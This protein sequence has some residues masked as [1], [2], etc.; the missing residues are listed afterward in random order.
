[1]LWDESADDLKLVGAAGL[2]VSGTTSLDG[3]VT[4]NDSGADVDFRVESDGNANMLFVDGGN[5]A[6]GIGTASPMTMLHIFEGEGLYPDDANNH[7]VVESDS[8]SYIGIGGGTSSD[9]G[10]HFGDSG[11]MARGRI[12]YLNASDAMSFN[13]AG[14]EAMRID[15]SGNVGIG[16]TDPSEA[17]L[18]IDNVT[19]GDAGL[20]IVQAQD[21]QG[22]YLD[23]DGNERGIYVEYAGTTNDALQII[24]EGLTTG[25]I[26]Y[27][28]SNTANT[29][30]RDL[31]RIRNNHA[32]ATGTTSLLV[33]Q[34]STGL[35][36][37]FLG[38]KIRTSGGIL[39]GTDTAAANALDD[40]EEGTWTPTYAVGGGGSVTG[41]TSTNVGT[42]T[43]VGRMVTCGVTSIYVGTTGTI[44]T[45]YTCDLPFTASNTG[46]E[47][48][49]GF[50]QETGQTG[51]GVLIKVANNSVTAAIW[52]YDGSAV[53][54]NAYFA[55]SF[56]YQAA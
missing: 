49:G 13:T 53:A 28:Y 45:Y 17:K 48:G 2:T 16:D 33:E 6:V 41:V 8:H 42:Y 34:D 11:G 38:S 25:K 52:E 12:A 27:F 20:K 18:S 9:V 31:V 40:Y 24:D 21:S 55:L 23:M 5:D 29:S 50:G 15:S 43:K 36:A 14:T 26:A 54:A 39:F 7:L 47:S 44:P 35:C 46:G 3:S 19:A 37:D 4:I 51:N 10:I 1:M 56:T 32:D 22:I 30:T